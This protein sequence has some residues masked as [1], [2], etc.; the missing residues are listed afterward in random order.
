VPVTF[1]I[2]I[3][4]IYFLTDDLIIG[5]ILFFRFSKLFYSMLTKNNHFIL[6][7]CGLSGSKVK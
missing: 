1:T 5:K 4:D 2:P 7:T 3:L 6:Q